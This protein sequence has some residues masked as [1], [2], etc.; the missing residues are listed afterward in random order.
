MTA[1]HVLTGGMDTPLRAGE[2]E[3]RYVAEDGRPQLA[4]LD[5]AGWQ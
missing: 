4:P 1:L 3:V 2:F 5:E